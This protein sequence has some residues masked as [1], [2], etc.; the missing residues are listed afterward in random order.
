MPIAWNW[1][2]NV[3]YELEKIVVKSASVFSPMELNAK[4]GLSLEEIAVKRRLIVDSKD[5]E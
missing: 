3:K 2:T 1:V 4:H 5:S